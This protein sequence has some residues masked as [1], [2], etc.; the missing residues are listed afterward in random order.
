MLEIRNLSAKIGRK[1][2]LEDINLKLVPHTFTAI[3]GKNGCGKSTLVSCINQMQPYTGEMLIAGRNLALMPER[4]RASLVSILP[5]SL[6]APHITVSELAALG[7][8]PYVD[9]GKHLTQEDKD[10]V[11]GS[12][13]TIGIDA[14][15]DCYIDELS[16]G[17]KQKAY[18]A[19]TLAQNTR[20]MVLDEPTTYMDMAY[21][22][23]FMET[24]DMLKKKHKKTLLVIM[25]NLNQAVRYADRL[26]VMD[27]GRIIAD[28]TKEEILESGMLEQVFG[29]KMYNDGEN[30]F[31]A[32]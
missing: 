19:M 22:H 5:Q 2:I 9:I 6:T 20:L 17:E 23:T 25:H 14:L 18:L 13:S 15:A 32:V 12:I 21:E 3:V 28:G 8:S 29:V 4:E 27:S 16:G 24:L 31:F 10:I 11:A 30:I 1:A 7:R 26:A